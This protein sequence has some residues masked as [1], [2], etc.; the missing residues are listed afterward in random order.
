MV[1]ARGLLSVA[2]HPGHKWCPAGSTLGSVLFNAFINNLDHET[3]LT[4]STFADDTKL[5][6]T[7]NTI[8]RRDTIQRNK[9]R[10]KK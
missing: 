9:D 2:P 10:L 6:G 1:V 4:T 8:Q 5:S 3:E 7:V